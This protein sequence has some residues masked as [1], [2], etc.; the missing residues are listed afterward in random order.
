MLVDLSLVAVG[1]APNV[2][3]RGLENVGF[4]FDKMG[5]KVNIPYPTLTEAIRLTPIFNNLMQRWLAW[6]R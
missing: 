2:E 1:C 4:E 6:Q 5:V 3:G